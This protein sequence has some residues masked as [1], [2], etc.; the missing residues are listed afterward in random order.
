MRWRDP[1]LSFPVIMEEECIIYG[2]S[3]NVYNSKGFGNRFMTWKDNRYIMLILIY[4]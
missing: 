4:H 3:R 1:V 2:T